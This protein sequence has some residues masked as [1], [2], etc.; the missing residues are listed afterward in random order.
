MKIQTDIT[1][2]DYVAFCRFVARNKIRAH[3]LARWVVALVAAVSIGLVLYWSGLVTDGL[4]FVAGFISV[5]LWFMIISRVQVF[6]VGPADNG[7]ILGKR[8]VSLEETGIRVVSEKHEFLYRWS[9]V[10]DVEV[11][12]QHLFIMVDSNAGIIIPLRTFVS[13]SERKQFVDEIR[14]NSGKLT[15]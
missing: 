7:F 2:Q 14:T 3:R 9:A 6:R 10:R 4:S 11:T 1:R 13:E 8:N 15:P 12:D 5:I